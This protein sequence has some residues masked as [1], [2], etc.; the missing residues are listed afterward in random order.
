MA[1]VTKPGSKARVREVMAEMIAEGKLIVGFCRCPKPV[2]QEHKSLLRQNVLP[3]VADLDNP[4]CR[5]L[6][7]GSTYGA[8]GF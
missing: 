4:K 8:A 1:Y 3:S 2:S 5:C 6:S 7:C